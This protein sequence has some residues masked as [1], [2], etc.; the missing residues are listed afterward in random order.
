MVS[1]YKG[2]ASLLYHACRRD[3]VEIAGVVIIHQHGRLQFVAQPQVHCQPGV[4]AE[5]IFKIESLSVEADRSVLLQGIYQQLAI[6]NISGK[7]V[8][9]VRAS[10]GTAQLA[11]WH[12]AP[13][14]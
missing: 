4:D 13:A 1:P 2:G 3:R 8:L 12:P 10:C 7:E 11:V 6:G 14:E 9:Q 5:V